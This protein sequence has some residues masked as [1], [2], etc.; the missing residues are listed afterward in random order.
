MHSGDGGALVQLH[1][2]CIKELTVAGGPFAARTVAGRFANLWEALQ[3][4]Y[5]LGEANRLQTLGPTDIGKR[6]K[7]PVLACNIA[8]S[9]HLIKP[10]IALL[11]DIGFF[12]DRDGH[13]LRCYE[14]YAEMNDIIWGN[15]LFIP[16]AEAMRLRDIFDDYLLHY[17]ALVVHGRRYNMYNFT[18]KI[19]YMWHK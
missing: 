3:T 11:K 10:M 8:A 17:N 19:H 15:G 6:S 9:R 5:P 1:G 14:L 18:T 12:S 4:K 13:R 16:D 7:F 2:G